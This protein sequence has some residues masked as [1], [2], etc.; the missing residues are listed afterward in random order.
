MA[1]GDRNSVNI[2]GQERA[3]Q[4]DTVSRTQRRDGLHSESPSML[5]GF[6]ST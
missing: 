2:A 3:E 1:Q 6:L 5:V 4:S